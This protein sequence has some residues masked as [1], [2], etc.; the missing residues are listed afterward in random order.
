ML[1]N[2]KYDVINSLVIKLRFDDNS[3]KEEVISVG[4]VVNCSYN[5]NGMRKTV[6]GTVKQIVADTNPCGKQRWYMYIDASSCGN[7]VLEKVE[8]EKIL[9]IDVLRKGAGLLSIHTP[10]NRMKV[11]DFRMSGDYLQVSSDYGKHWYNVAKLANETYPVH[12]EYQELAIRI[13]SLLPPHMNPGV[14]SDL[15]VALVQLFK[16]ISPE[17]ID[18][19]RIE[20]KLDTTIEDVSENASNIDYISRVYA[21]ANQGDEDESEGL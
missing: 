14:K 3:V 21:L 7:A 8:V 6:E 12:A 15:V 9:D 18:I 2:I 1:L 11:T 19:R 13:A 20:E 16:D 5:K 10:G 4:D 17:D